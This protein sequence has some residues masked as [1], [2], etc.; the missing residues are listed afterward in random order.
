MFEQLM[1]ANYDSKLLEDAKELIKE[2]RL[3]YKDIFQFILKFVNNTN[4]KSECMG[5]VVSLVI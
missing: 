5:I 3:K 4:K 1:K 2:D